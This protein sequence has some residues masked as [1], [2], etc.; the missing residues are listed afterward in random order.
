MDATPSVATLDVNGPL[1]ASVVRRGIERILP[2]VRACYRAAAAT[3]KRTLAVNVS[4]RFDIDENSSATNVSGGV[5][6][7]GSLSS[8]VKNAIGQI[9][10]QQAPDVGIA[11]V[12]VTIRFTPL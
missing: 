4:L 8:C 11:Q 9:Q 6:S 10:T 5:T 3:Q 2:S 12:A 7:F 1:P